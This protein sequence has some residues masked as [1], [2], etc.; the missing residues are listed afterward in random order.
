MFRC[1]GSVAARIVLVAGIWGAF[2]ACGSGDDRVVVFA[3][4]SLTD[5]FDRLETEFESANPDVD[6]VVNTAGSSSLVAQLSDG[7]PADILVTADVDTMGRAV[8]SSSIAADPVVLA[9]NGLVIAV[10]RG[11]PLAIES[12]DDLS[13]VVVVLAAPEVPAGAYA[14][15]VLECAGVDVEP[16]SF[17]QSVRSV[18]SKVALG[19]A[20]AGLVYLTDISDALEAVQVPANCQVSAEYPIVL[21]SETPAARRFLSF[22]TG[23]DGAGVLTDAGFELP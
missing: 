8:A 13:D 10:E 22:V 11:N 12:L 23:S 7:A 18:A 3:A 14:R 2:A 20:D 6:I 5:V 21:I 1:R 9:R 16:A 17:E 19:E 4:S 15:T